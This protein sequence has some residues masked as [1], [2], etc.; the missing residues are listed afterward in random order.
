[1]TTAT[2]KGR[3]CSGAWGHTLVM[4]SRAR[5]SKEVAFTLDLSNK[6]QAMQKK[7]NQDLN[8]RGIGKARHGTL[9]S[10]QCQTLRE[11]DGF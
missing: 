11:L 5:L 2:K 4:G 10:R 3:L 7:K 8:L 6:E 9:Q 1:M